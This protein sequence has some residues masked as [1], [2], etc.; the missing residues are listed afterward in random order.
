[1]NS[2]HRNIA[3]CIIF[4][5]I[6]CG[7][8]S[9]YWMI[10]LNDDMLDALQEEGTS[11]G[12]V[13]LLSLITCGIYGLYWMYQMGTRVDR[14]NS[15]YGRYTDNSGMLYLVVS[16]LGFGIILYVVMQ[17]ELNHYYLYNNQR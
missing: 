14:L 13:F 2:R 16:L 10:V 1:M 4:T 7:I 8:Y 15:R 17:N 5:L 11:G 12:M 3:L 6:T 9:I